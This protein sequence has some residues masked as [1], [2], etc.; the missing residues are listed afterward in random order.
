MNDKGK[1]FTDSDRCILPKLCLEG[2]D[3]E[4]TCCC[5]KCGNNQRR[6]DNG[7]KGS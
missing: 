7:Q 3:H 5:E 1:G 2:G 6:I 4:W